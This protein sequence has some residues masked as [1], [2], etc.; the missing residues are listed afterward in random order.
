MSGTDENVPEKIA[1]SQSLNQ[2][3]SP[4]I[5][6]HALKSIHVFPLLI[7]K[8]DP[9]RQRSDEAALHRRHDVNIPVHF[10]P[11]IQLRVDVREQV[12]GEDG[13][14]KGLDALEEKD[15]EDDLVDMVGEGPEFQQV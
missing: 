13:R 2:S 12:G 10:C 8:H 11:P 5:P 3:T 14:D 15:R 6:I 7:C 9:Q 1:N 4:S